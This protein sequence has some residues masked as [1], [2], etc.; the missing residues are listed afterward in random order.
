MTEPMTHEEIEAFAERAP[1][2]KDGPLWSLLDWSF[3][4]AGMA[5]TIR[6]PLADVMLAAVPDN[7]RAQ[8]EAI[9][10]EFIRV[11]KIEKT[12]VTIYQEQYDELTRLRAQVEQLRA[13]LKTVKVDSIQRPLQT[14][15][16][17]AL[18][19]TAQKGETRG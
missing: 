3:W 8:A 4:G 5:D 18:Y 6:E 16:H 2:R 15:A 12:G 11:R 13:A 10:A 1:E 14:L 17:T 19:G 7:V 9:M